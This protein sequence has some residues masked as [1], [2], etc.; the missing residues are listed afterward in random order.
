[1]FIRY[2]VGALTYGYKA[3][4]MPAVRFDQF[5][6]SRET[7]IGMHLTFVTKFVALQLVYFDGVRLGIQYMLFTFQSLHMQLCFFE[8]GMP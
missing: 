8:C 1:L 7:V 4:V 2:N 6:M 5:E 3:N